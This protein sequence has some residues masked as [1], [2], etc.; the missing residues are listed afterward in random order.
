MPIPIGQ[1]TTA[2]LDDNEQIFFARQL[3]QIE[4]RLY[5]IEYPDLKGRTHFPLNFE[6]GPAVQSFT[7]RVFDRT[8][9]AQVGLN[10]PR[11]GIKAQ[12][13]S[14]VVKSFTDSYGYNFQEIRNANAV[15][16][17]LDDALARAARRAIA[18]L[19]DEAIYMG[20]PELNMPGA[21][22]HPNFGINLAG[23]AISDAST[24]KQIL[25][26]FNNMFNQFPILT[27]GK[28]RANA[29]L[30]P[31]DVHTYQTTTP[32]NESNSSNLKLMDMIQKAHPQVEFD[33]C[34]YCDG[35]GDAGEDIMFAYERDSTNMQVRIPHDFETL[36]TVGPNEKYEYVTGCH[37]RF[38]GLQ[39][40]FAYA[41]I[42]YLK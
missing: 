30:M 28:H 31:L 35:A 1:L 4:E 17:S 32:W 5:E 26:V 39:V 15:N 11:V 10:F 20:L 40:R 2:R 7:Y 3:E 9:V 36:E 18:E 21:F 27:K 29:C 22:T 13:K 16:M 12:E 14:T 6:G 33:W 8:G 23:F 37:E 38:G 41:S 24:S 42:T 25:S 34:N 19:E